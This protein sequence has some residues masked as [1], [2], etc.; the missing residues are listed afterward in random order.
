[1]FSYSMALSRLFCLAALA[2]HA[3]VTTSSTPPECQ[4]LAPSCDPTQSWACGTYGGMQSVYGAYPTIPTRG[5]DYFCNASTNRCECHMDGY[6]PTTCLPDVNGCTMCQVDRSLSSFSSAYPGFIPYDS[7]GDSM[8]YCFNQIFD[9]SSFRREIRAVGVYEPASSQIAVNLRVCTDA[10]DLSKPVVLLLTS[11]DPVQWVISSADQYVLDNLDLER[12][13]ALAYYYADTSVR[14]QDELNPNATTEIAVKYPHG[15]EWNSGY[16]HGSDSGGGTTAKMLYYTY[17]VLGDFAYSFIGE[18]RAS[19]IDVCVGDQNVAMLDAAAYTGIVAP[20]RSPTAS[21]T[22]EPTQGPTTTV[23]TESSVSPIGAPT[24][25]PTV[26]TA[27]LTTGMETAPPTS[28]QRITDAPSARPSVSRTDG[29]TANPTLE[30]TTS[31][32]FA[33]ATPLSTN[34]GPG[35][36]SAGTL[37]S[38][39]V[40]VL[41]SIVCSLQVLINNL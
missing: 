30:P 16:G 34:D 39:W 14:V 29:P 36:L 10:P 17:S 18:Y 4:Y 15:G 13:E 40:F 1:M 22:S 35:D 25:E 21:P 8:Y 27:L 32:A 38:P 9:Y 12:I 7:G 33:S 37:V 11:Y 31:T 5:T 2:V 24:A 19:A 3:F 6:K 41:S 23:P 26:A 28:S 20:T